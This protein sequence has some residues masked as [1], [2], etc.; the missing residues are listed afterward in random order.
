MKNKQFIKDGILKKSDH[1]IYSLFLKLK[2]H[3]ANF[4][5]EKNSIKE[6]E[7][8]I[9]LTIIEPTK[10]EINKKKRISYQ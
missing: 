5:L 7:E 9:K 3:E 6:D 1:L 8:G 2:M 10:E 4:I